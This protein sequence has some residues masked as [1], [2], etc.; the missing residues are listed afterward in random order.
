M[1]LPAVK[2]LTTGHGQWLP[3]P[4]ASTASADVEPGSMATTRSDRT[5]CIGRCTP[6]P[7]ENRDA[8]SEAV[9]KI[10]PMRWYHQVNLWIHE[11]LALVGFSASVAGSWHYRTVKG[12]YTA[13]SP[14]PHAYRANRNYVPPVE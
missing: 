14:S 13:Q 2:V 12:A 10:A 3:T 4:W 11:P 9:S 8:S 6:P 1:S 5:R 7:D